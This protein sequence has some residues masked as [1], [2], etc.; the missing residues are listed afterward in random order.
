MLGFVC[1]L[2][3]LTFASCP[4]PGRNYREPTDSMRSSSIADSSSSTY[5]S[6]W[7]T[8]FDLRNNHHHHPLGQNVK[9]QKGGISTAAVNPEPHTIHSSSTSNEY[10]YGKYTT[11]PTGAFVPKPQ[12]KIQKPHHEIGRRKRNSRG[13]IGP[14]FQR[15]W[16]GTPC[17][18][19]PREATPLARAAR[20]ALPR[21]RHRL[22]ARADCPNSPCPR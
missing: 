12:K 16:S 14:R 10:E 3:R 18:S 20:L 15:T 5:S 6:T 4:V 2:P 8:L 11:Y 7:T 17:L 21:R 1:G 19:T 9:S 22:L 13:H